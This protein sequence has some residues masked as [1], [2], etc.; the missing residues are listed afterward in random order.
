MGYNNPAPF[1]TGVLDAHRQS[2]S[3]HLMQGIYGLV[4][5]HLTTRA[6][7]VDPRFV[8]AKNMPTL[9]LQLCNL[10]RVPPARLH[11]VRRFDKKRVPRPLLVLEAKLLQHYVHGWI[12][13]PR[14]PLRSGPSVWPQCESCFSQESWARHVA[15]RHLGRVVPSSFPENSCRC[16]PRTQCEVDLRS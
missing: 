9:A 6:A 7:G 14:C 8:R 11:N 10:E 12:V 5:P 16:T 4:N 2:G 15:K 3:T 1:A 13:L